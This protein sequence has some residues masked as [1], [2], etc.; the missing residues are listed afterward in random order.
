MYVLRCSDESLYCGASKDVH[1]R[2]SQHN[3]GKGAAYTRS[4][5]PCQIVGYWR[6]GSCED[7]LVAEHRFK[8]LNRDEK[9][10][11]LEEKAWRDGLWCGQ[12]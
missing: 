5:K 4:R 10:K 8:Q 7:A 11:V 9:L 1:R 12:A 3:S 2:V 6:Y